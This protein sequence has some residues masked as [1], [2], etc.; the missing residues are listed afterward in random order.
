MSAHGSSELTTFFEGTL[1]ISSD[2]NAHDDTP[3]SD[4]G[5]DTNRSE[6]EGSGN[7]ENGT[8]DSDHKTLVIVD[9]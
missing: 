2:T 5:E 6:G 4:P 1:T 7:H 8:N 9:R 3:H